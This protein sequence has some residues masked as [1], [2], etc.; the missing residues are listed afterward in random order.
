MKLLSMFSVALLSAL[1]AGCDGDGEGI[2][3]TTD[4]TADRTETVEET[5]GAVT[6]DTGSETIDP[7]DTGTLSDFDIHET[8]AIEAT[9]EWSSGPPKVAVT[10]VHD[11]TVGVTHDSAESPTTLIMQA[12]QDLLDNSNGWSLWVFNPDAQE[13]VTIYFT[14]RFTPD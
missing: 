4:T 6:I 10:L 5:K 3:V 12:T 7:L 2:G 13:S 1:V 14:V 8:G 9:I 11:S